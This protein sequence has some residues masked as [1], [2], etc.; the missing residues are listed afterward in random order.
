MGWEAM[1]GRGTA[2]VAVAAVMLGMG[3]RGRAQVLA[4]ELA[5]GG[6]DLQKAR[7]R[8]GWSSMNESMN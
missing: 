4:E 7:G 2:E 8:G 5:E 1:E 6:E 3:R